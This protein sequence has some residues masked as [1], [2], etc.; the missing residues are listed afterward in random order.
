M[1]FI[2]GGIYQNDQNQTWNAPNLKLLED[3]SHSTLEVLLLKCPQNLNK[4]WNDLRLLLEL[5]VVLLQIF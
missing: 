5:Y 4:N 3:S 1:E 2:F